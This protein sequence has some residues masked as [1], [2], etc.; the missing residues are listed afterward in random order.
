MNE[1]NQLCNRIAIINK[2]RLVAIDAPEKL[3]AATNSLHS[4]EVSF[5][6]TVSSEMLEEIPG[7]NS[8]KK[9]GDKHRLYTE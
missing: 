7:I 5:D 8:V 4:V 3:K 1:A 9:L 6:S 2:G